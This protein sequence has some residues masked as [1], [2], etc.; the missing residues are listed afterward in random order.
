VSAIGLAELALAARS[1]AGAYSRCWQSYLAILAVLAVY[2]VLKLT[3][4]LLAKQLE[5]PKHLR[6]H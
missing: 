1:V 2:L 3:L 6:G 4:P 5:T